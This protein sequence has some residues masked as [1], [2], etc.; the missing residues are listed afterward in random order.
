MTS[1]IL[2]EKGVC[3]NFLS[4]S[5]SLF[6]LFLLYPFNSFQTASAIS[7]DVLFF[8]PF[9]TQV[10]GQKTQPTLNS[11]EYSEPLLMGH[12]SFPLFSN[13]P[14]SNVLSLL[15]FPWECLPV[16][17]LLQYEVL[18]FKQNEHGGT[19]INMQRL[20]QYPNLEELI[21]LVELFEQLEQLKVSEHEYW[22]VQFV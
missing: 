5:L 17:N 8:Y 19:V 3:T 21:P 2:L 7:L 6:G 15:K 9:G 12:P 14:Y 22:D 4:Y 18:G 16:P 20:S 13:Y 11:Y 10:H 1:D